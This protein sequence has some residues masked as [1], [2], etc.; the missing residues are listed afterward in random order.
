MEKF[1]DM[2][3]NIF[4]DKNEKIYHEKLKSPNIKQRISSSN[5]TKNIVSEQIQL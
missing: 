4:Y 1:L 5:D 2:T 3:T